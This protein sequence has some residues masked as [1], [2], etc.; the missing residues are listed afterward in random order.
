LSRHK[1]RGDGIKA[2]RKKLHQI[3][4]LYLGDPDY[5]K[6]LN[7]L[8]TAVQSA[9]PELLKASCSHIMSTHATTRERLP[10]LDTFYRQIFEVT[11]KPGTLLDIACGL[12]PLSFPWMNLPTATHYYAYDIHQKR[13]TFL[14]QFFSLLGLLPLAKFQDVLTHFPEEKADV[15]FIFKEVH[16][17]ERRRQGCTLPLLD[18]LQV[19]YIVV[20][21]PTKSLS[22]RR[23]LAGQY[24]QLFYDMVKGR[25]WP[26][27]EIEFE[28]ELIFCVDKS[29]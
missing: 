20:S 5:A 25:P 4:A 1:K 3:V 23:D 15:A 27:T 12:N 2:V 19:H 8:E 28:D 21:F 6:A 29:R 14:N 9:N 26:V 13:V 16:R 22:G 18:A 24:H 10:M 17:F 7:E 11:G